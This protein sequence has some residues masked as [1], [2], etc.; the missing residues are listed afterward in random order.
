MKK[1][2]ELLQDP[3]FLV[4]GAPPAYGKT[5]LLQLLEREYKKEGYWVKR[6]ALRGEGSDD[7]TSIYKNHTGIDLKQEVIVQRTIIP[8]TLSSF[9]CAGELFHA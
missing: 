3:Q 5:P 2:T 1:V 6:F 7:L 9:K 4:V 8:R